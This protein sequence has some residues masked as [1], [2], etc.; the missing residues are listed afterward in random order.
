MQV[1]ARGIF[2]PD[3]RDIRATTI[4]DSLAV[5]TCAENALEADIKVWCCTNSVNSKPT[6]AAITCTAVALR[7]KSIAERKASKASALLGNPLTDAIRPRS[8][9]DSSSG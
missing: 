6:P 8:P 3:S 2:K 1:A 9:T 5:P 7:G 4:D